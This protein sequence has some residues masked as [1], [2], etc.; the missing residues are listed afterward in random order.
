[1][2]RHA[3][4]LLFALAWP[5][6]LVAG[7]AEDAQA[8]FEK[9]FPTFVQGNCEGVASLFAPDAQFYGTQSREL[10]TAHEGVREYFATALC[11][12]PAPV[13]AVPLGAKSQALS[14]S[15]VLISGSWQSERTVDG[16]LVVGGPFRTT[17]VMQKRGD[18]WLIVQ[19]HNSPRPAP[20]PAPTK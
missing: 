17:A 12:N 6:L 15:V 5:P 16:K 8:A 11:K 14:D 18:R 3:I 2:K 4:A 7:P 9:F 19:F 10:V 1:M 13:K 20:P